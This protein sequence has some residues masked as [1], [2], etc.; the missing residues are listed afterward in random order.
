MSVPARTED[1]NVEVELRISPNA[2]CPV[3]RYEEDVTD[4]KHYAHRQGLQCDIYYED[5]ATGGEEVLHSRRK[6][7]EPCPATVFQTHDCIPL[8]TDIDGGRFRVSTRLPSRQSIPE[9]LEDLKAV[10]DRVSIQRVSIS[11]LRAEN[12]LRTVDL[13]PL[14]EK[15]REAMELAVRRGFY[16]QPKETTISALA[17]ELDLSQSA[18]S[19]RLHAAEQKLVE[20]LFDAEDFE[21]R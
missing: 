16:E 20:Q 21:P 12:D 18:L 3:R 14:T 13:Q 5:P 9:L 19:Q 17:E 4:V 7:S 10:A 1:R 11:G 2:D 8:I 6:L 15:Q